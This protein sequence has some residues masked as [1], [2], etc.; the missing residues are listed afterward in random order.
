MDLSGHTQPVRAVAWSPNGK[1]LASARS[2]GTV[3]VWNAATGKRLLTYRGHQ[4][5]VGSLAWSPDGK[6]IASVADD[7]QVWQA[8]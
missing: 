8:G 5:I 3:Q 4:D 2:D 6:H 1:R 7:V